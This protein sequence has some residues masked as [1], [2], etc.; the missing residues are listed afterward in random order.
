MPAAVT[1]PAYVSVAPPQFADSPPPRQ[2]PDY[3]R[4]LRRR[5]WIVVCAVIVAT[6]CAYAVVHSQA[7]KYESTAT[8]MLD[9]S[10]PVEVVLQTPANRSLDPE[11]DVNT[12]VALVKSA[13]LATRVKRRLSL[14]LSIREI[15][16]EVHAE[17]RGNSSVLAVTVKDASPRRAARIANAFALEYQRF[18][19]TAAR[20]A[21]LQAI[22]LAEQRLASLT[23]QDRRGAVGRS[24]KTRLGQLQI[25][26]TLQTGGVQP[27]DAASVAASPASPRPA[28]AVAIGAVLGLI[29]GGLLAIALEFT[30]RRLKNEEEIERTTALEIVGR[31]PVRTRGAKRRGAIRAWPRGVR[32]IKAASTASV[33]MPLTAPW[34]DHGRGSTRS[35][36]AEQVRATD[37][38]LKSAGRASMP[39]PGRGD[40]PAPLDV[41]PGER[42]ALAALA[43]NIRFLGLGG[44]RQTIM[45][46]SASSS[47]GKTSITLGVGAALA[48][49]GYRVI[50]IE[51]DLRQPAF[52]RYAPV[53]GRRLGTQGLVGLLIGSASL[54]NVL[55]ELDPTT[56]L[57]V[58]STSIERG[59]FAVLPAG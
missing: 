45:L 30:D 44:G 32:R 57:P 46:A 7:K 41:W 51:G 55:V 15:L 1:Q 31:I 53:G 38:S 2:L 8:L 6:G 33:P 59:Y 13:T 49:I 11:R 17:T 58:D 25:A 42:E 20:A 48:R 24:L 43:A 23:P 19:R 4:A 22:Q 16:A 35:G 5:W 34:E 36:G 26:A 10:Q 21:Y 37:T 9:N 12:S 52:A 29:V 14:T 50:A 56:G 27:V 28:V 39:K 3:I 40:R 18:R 54:E 47:D